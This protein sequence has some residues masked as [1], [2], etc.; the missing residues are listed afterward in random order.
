MIL[1]QRNWNS[2]SIQTA[3]ATALNIL[4][5]HEGGRA[6]GGEMKTSYM[7][8]SVEMRDSILLFP[9]ESVTK[10]RASGQVKRE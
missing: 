4:P 6:K 1:T 9:F 5:E 7:W 3:R 10:E 2:Q 8:P